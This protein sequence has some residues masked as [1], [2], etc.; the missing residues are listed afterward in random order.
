MISDL[1]NPAYLRSL[2]D[3]DE[4]NEEFFFPFL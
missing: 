2:L 1:F 4:K 3:T